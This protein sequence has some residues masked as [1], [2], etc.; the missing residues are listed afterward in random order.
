[1]S[2]I[3]EIPE[4]EY[5]IRE[6]QADYKHE[7][8]NGRMVAMSGASEA[9]NLIAV[10]LVVALA[11]RLKN[12]PCRVFASDM[13]VKVVAAHFYTYP[14][15]SVVCGESQFDKRDKQALVNPRLI[16][17]ILSNSTEQYD[18]GQKFDYYKQLASLEEYVLVAQDRMEVECYRRDLGRWTHRRF[19]RED[20]IIALPSVE[21]EISIGEI[22]DK[23]NL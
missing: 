22:Y 16:A 15:I 18:R 3:Y 11:T 4:D 8:R 2:G 19:T 14:D 13:R 12:G 17:E 5:L 6:P 21:C 23:I 1:M 20:A 9:H 7:Y 10:N